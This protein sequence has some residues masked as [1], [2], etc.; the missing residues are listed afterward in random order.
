MMGAGIAYVCARAGME[1]VLKDVARRERREGQGLL[2]EA[3]RQGDRPR[4][5]TEEKKA[6]LLGRITATADP[7]DLAGCD[8]VIEAVFEDPALKDEGVRRDRCRT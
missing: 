3:A 2:G 7:A 8:L 4:P 6:E 5:L 1:V